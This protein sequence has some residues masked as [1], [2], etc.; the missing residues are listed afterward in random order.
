MDE[1]SPGQK[2]VMQMTWETYRHKSGYSEYFGLDTNDDVTCTWSE[3]RAL[4]RLAAVNV[5]LRFSFLHIPAVSA[6]DQR[7][8]GANR[9]SNEHSTSYF[10]LSDSSFL[11]TISF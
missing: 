9:V 6:R 5:P 4:A 2:E 1:F 8:S 11:I 10:M 7:N 3:V